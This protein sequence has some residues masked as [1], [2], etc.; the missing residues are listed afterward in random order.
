M[1]P[2]QTGDE[3]PFANGVVEDTIEIMENNCQ[4]LM[5]KSDKLHELD[6]KNRGD[7]QSGRVE[8]QGPTRLSEVGTYTCRNIRLGSFLFPTLLPKHFF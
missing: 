2:D 8:F 6:L 4:K 1:L 7:G 3:N 5:Q